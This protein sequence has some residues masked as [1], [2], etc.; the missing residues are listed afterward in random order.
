MAN[1]NDTKVDFWGELFVAGDTIA[2]PIRRSSHMWIET[3]EVIDF[4]FDYVKVRKDSGRT[5]KIYNYGNAFIK[6]RP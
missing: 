1:G 3:A 5:A 4:G 6:V 2:Y